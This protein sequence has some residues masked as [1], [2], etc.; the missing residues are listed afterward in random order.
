MN[1]RVLVVDDDV[2]I[3][4][5]LSRVLRDEGYEVVLAAGGLEA[6]A[7]FEPEDFDILLLDL[8]LTNQTGW[9]VLEHLKTRA[10]LIRV[11]II[12]GVPN[13]SCRARAAGASALLE[14]PIEVSAMLKTLQALV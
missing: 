2:V 13:Q 5:S 6:A 4:E 7:R 9:E 1:G 14:K 11:V 8:N 10:P 12:T 3:R